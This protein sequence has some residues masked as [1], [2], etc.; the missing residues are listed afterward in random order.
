MGK[1]IAPLGPSLGLV[2]V[3]DDVGHEMLLT[4]IDGR[5]KGARALL[6]MEALINT[7]SHEELDDGSVTK[8]NGKMQRGLMVRNAKEVE[9]NGYGISIGLITANG[10]VEKGL[11][12]SKPI[13]T[14]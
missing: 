11:V 13:D 12:V 2:V 10:K 5:I 14:E 6:I 9:C 3:D 7:G 1:V 8:A 4:G